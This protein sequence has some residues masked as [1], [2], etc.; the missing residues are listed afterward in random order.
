[1]GQSLTRGNEFVFR[2]LKRTL[3]NLFKVSY[4]SVAACSDGGYV[5]FSTCWAGFTD[6]IGASGV[7]INDVA[8]GLWVMATEVAQ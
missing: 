2:N 5:F 3:K 7:W 1:M 8:R 4:F 6:Q